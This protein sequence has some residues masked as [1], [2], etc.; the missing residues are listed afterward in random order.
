MAAIIVEDLEINQGEDWTWKWIVKDPVTGD[1]LDLT[2]WTGKGEIRMQP[3]D[4]VLYTWVTGTNMTLNEDGEV[5]ITVP[6]ASSTAWT[7]GALVAR[8]DIELT[9]GSGKKVRLVEGD[10]K[11]SLEVTQ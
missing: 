9:N 5:L 1:P 10:V 11:V 7:W 4:P 8:Y 2:G 6:H 3:G